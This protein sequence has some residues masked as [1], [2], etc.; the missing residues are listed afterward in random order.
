ME[1]TPRAGV[2]LRL[3]VGGAV[4]APVTAILFP[5][6]HGK[7]EVT[8]HGTLKGKLNGNFLVR[9]RKHLAANGLAYA[10]F[11]APSDRLQGKGLTWAYRSGSEHA[12]DIMAAVEAIR[13]KTGKP[14]WLVGTSRGSTSVANAASRHPGGGFAGIVLTSGRGVE[15]DGN[16][17]DFDLGK[18]SVPVLIAHHRNDG[19][20]K[21]PFSGMEDVAGK[22]K[23]AEI[24]AFDGGDAG[25]AKN[26]CGGK[27]H[28]GFLKIEK[29]VV[30]KIADWIKQH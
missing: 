9:T 6:G 19:C 4:D 22:I 28:H 14:V 11:D 16:I 30:K 26:V 5:G 7:V 24:M 2:T 3:L 10:V 21:T 18:I 17:L 25:K 13:Q 20:K 27:S 12:A 29:K 15:G 8:E 23:G 1:I